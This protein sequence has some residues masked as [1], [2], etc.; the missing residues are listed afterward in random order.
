MLGI[1]E[2]KLRYPANTFEYD[3]TCYMYYLSLDN[4]VFDCGSPT[5]A[6]LSRLKKSTI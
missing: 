2:K 1:F 4:Q 5:W 3:F 6:L